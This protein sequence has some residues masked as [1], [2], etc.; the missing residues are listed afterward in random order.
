MQSRKGFDSG[1]GGMPDPFARLVDP[2]RS[3]I[4]APASL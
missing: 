2:A 3:L 1:T 4:P